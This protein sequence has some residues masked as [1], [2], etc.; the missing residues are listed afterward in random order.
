M[1][2]VNRYTNDQKELLTET[3]KM[4]EMQVAGLIPDD[5]RTASEALNHGKTCS[6]SWHRRQRV[7]Q[8]YVREIDQLIAEKGA[9]NRAE[10][11]RATEQ[12]RVVLR[13]I[14]PEFRL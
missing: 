8:W 11:G 14:S 7:G 10:A 2:I 13:S 9:G 3:E 12:N 6:R 4:L 1:L 5:Y